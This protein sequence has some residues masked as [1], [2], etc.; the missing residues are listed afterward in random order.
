MEN[1]L[2]FLYWRIDALQNNLSRLKKENK[3]LKKIIKEINNYKII[4]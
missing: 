4:E 3:N 1:L 2:E